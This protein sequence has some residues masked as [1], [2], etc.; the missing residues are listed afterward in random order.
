MLR[1]WTFKIELNADNKQVPIYKQLA[2]QIQEMIESG[3]LKEGELLPGGREIAQQLNVSRKTVLSAMDLLVFSGWLEN[4]ER[5]GLFVRHP[6]GKIV[7]NQMPAPVVSKPEQP[8]SA[9]VSS[10]VVDDGCPDTQ[11]VP[12][13]SLSSAFRQFFNRAA[14]WQMLGYDSP[15]GN[16]KLRSTVAQGICHERGLK[17]SAEQLMLTRG[18]QQ[19]LYIM[20][21]AL[22]HPGDAIVMEKPGYHN[23]RLAFESAGL[24]VIAIDVDEAGLQTDVLEKLLE[25]NPSIK[26]VYLTPRYQYPTTVT[27]SAT[28]RHH[29][30][31][32]V[33]RHGLLVVE[34]DF[35][36]HFDFSE[37][38]I[39]PLSVLLPPEHYV[40]IGTFS[41]IMAPALRLGFMVTTAAFITRMG[42][43]RKL[44]D[45]QGD[46]VMER[47]I[48]DLIE[49]GELKRHIRKSQKLYRE[50]L[51][52][53]SNL[54]QKELGNKVKYK[55]PHGGLAL[56]MEVPAN[57]SEKLA[58]C[59]ISVKVETLSPKRFGIRL[60]YASMQKEQMDFLVEALKKCLS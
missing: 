11:L 1:Q 33:T 7:R 25:E 14:R 17:A 41:K 45:M 20:A 22:L 21:H 9:S 48:L 8:V 2:E 3:I 24:Q 31:E 13:K 15:L 49:S 42:D 59:G 44:V 12:F 39:K 56:W 43:Y 19:A 46:N 35:G 6:N 4:R 10:L 60:G 50:R 28:R 23:A 34:D 51:L 58:Q 32:L 30:V 16:V 38:H 26:A 57:V 18:S 40:Y 27:L 53:A 55:K 36:C 52:Y 5:V 47:A 29:I 37:H 54:I